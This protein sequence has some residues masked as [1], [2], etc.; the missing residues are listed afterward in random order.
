MYGNVIAKDAS[1]DSLTSYDVDHIFPWS[2]GGKSTMANFASV[3]SAANQYVKNDHILQTLELSSLQCGLQINQLL[4]LVSFVINYNEKL[5]SPS[6]KTMKALF[7]RLR[8]W[9]MN[10]VRKGESWYRFQ[11]EVHHTCNGHE[12]WCFF[13]N[14]NMSELNLLKFTHIIPVAVSLSEEKEQ[15]KVWG[16]NKTG[17]SCKSC[18]KI[19]TFCKLH[20]RDDIIKEEVLSIEVA[21]VK[22]EDE[23]LSVE[24]RIYGVNKNGLACQLCKRLQGFCKRHQDQMRTED[25]RKHPS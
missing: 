6:R 7:D 20:V 18:Q 4:A 15:V 9:L 14:R 11:Q 17:K 22:A 10:S 16:V 5:S 25:P 8:S 19:K 24:E 2:R 3:Q 21:E 1:T 13:V 12:L 23:A